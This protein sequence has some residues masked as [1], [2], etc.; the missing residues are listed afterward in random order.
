MGI[1]HKRENLTMPA[2]NA[3]FCHASS[4]LSIESGRTFL[5]PPLIARTVSLRNPDPRYVRNWAVIHG[6]IPADGKVL[7]LCEA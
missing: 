6:L 3:Y 7:V 1:T 5:V 4:Q 2:A